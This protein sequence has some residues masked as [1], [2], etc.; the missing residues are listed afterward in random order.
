M[1][2]DKHRSADKQCNLALRSGSRARGENFAESKCHRRPPFKF[3]VPARPAG[4]LSSLSL[5]S[6]YRFCSVFFLSVNRNIGSREGVCF[7]A[8]QRRIFFG[9]MPGIEEFLLNRP[10]AA[11]FRV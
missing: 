11:A 5:G 2:H 4:T 10:E 7:F 8:P 1:W 6:D 3:F 9:L